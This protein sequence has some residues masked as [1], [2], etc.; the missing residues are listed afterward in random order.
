MSIKMR[1]ILLVD[2]EKSITNALQRELRD[3]AKER[4]LETLC[5]SSGAEGLGILSEHGEEIALIIS[6]LKMPEMKG[7]DFLLEVRNSFPHIV[8]ILLTGFPEVGEIAKVVKAG[9]FSFV[10]K[11]WESEYLIAEVTKAYDYSEVRRQRDGY[12]KTIEEELKWA[13]RLQKNLLKP[14]LPSVEGIDFKVISQSIPG[15]H[16]GGDYFDVISLG[17]DRFLILIGEVQDRGIKAAFVTG[18]LKAIIYSEYV[19]STLG[20]DFS[21]SDFLRWLNGRMD[22]EFKSGSEL[23]VTFFCGVLD[24]VK[25]TFLYANASHS[26]PFIVH[27]G[28]ATA[29]PVAGPAICMKNRA[30]YTDSTAYFYPRDI[31]VFHTSGVTRKSELDVK[32]II[33]LKPILEAFEYRA[34]FH[35]KV[36]ASVLASRQVKMFERGATLMT[37]RIH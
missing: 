17:G 3:W 9:V 11:P 28:K 12:L 33:Q 15:L 16:C 35:K 5:A 34:D 4:S 21:P 1:F 30:E 14:N 20:H 6:D 37:A 24:L 26:K 18:I 19:R 27:T 29:L 10:L 25:L 23:C 2:D 32:D 31:F 8:S 13:G 7:S 36:L 22:F